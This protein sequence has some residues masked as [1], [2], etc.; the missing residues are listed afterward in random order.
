MEASIESQLRY[1]EE[2][3]GTE[4]AGD[5]LPNRFLGLIRQA[6]EK[7]GRK[8]VVLFDEYDK[9][10]IQTIENE[11]VNEEVR[12]ALKSFYGVLKTADPW[13]RFVMLTGV[14][15][16]S[17]ISIFSDLNQLVDVSFDEKYGSL[18]GITDTELTVNFT[19]EIEKLAEKQK[20]NFEEAHAEMRKRYNGYCFAPDCEKVYNPFSVLNTLEKKW[21][22][23]YWFK[24]GTPTFLIR[25]LKDIHFNIP[26]LAAGVSISP[27]NIDDYRLKGDDPIPLLY[28]TG[29]L[30]IKGYE[31]QLGE[32]ILGFPN[33]EVKYGFLEELLDYYAPKGSY[34]LQLSARD[35]MKDLYKND[36]A[37]FMTRLGSLIECIPYD[38]KEESEH[39][40]HTVVHLLFML[41][42]QFAL[43]EVHT[44][45]GRA[46][47][48]VMTDNA[49]YIFEFKITG[50]KEGD[51]AEAA[52]KQ[53]DEKDY[54]G[55][56]RASGKKL[57]RIA[58]EYDLA[59]RKLGAWKMLS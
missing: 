38:N 48:V 32:Y 50:A 1:Y 33:E 13:L 2:T 25:Q 51:K 5:P 34:Y 7:S 23:Y 44:H 14:T 6:S 26:D 47:S 39:Y 24:T 30:T 56:Y 45:H 53:I 58:A 46:D 22:D 57:V 10:L 40:F 12:T 16:F 27:R 9:P 29:Y 43:A 21:F 59:N 55:P 18:C 42:G 15:K 49:V 20:M 36:I 11:T 19:P 54:L 8:A 17:R 41:T 35:F 52:L 31:S 4:A 3:W 37:S 28:Q